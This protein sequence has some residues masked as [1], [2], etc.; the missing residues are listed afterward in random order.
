MH[1]LTK[2]RFVE[3]GVPWIK[4][5]FP[6]Q[7]ECFSAFHTS[8]TAD[9]AN[10]LHNISLRTLPKLHSALRAKDL[11]LVICRTMS[12]APWHWQWINRELFSR[13][14]LQGASRLSA[15][16]GPQMLRVPIS[17]PIAVLDTEDYPVIAQNNFFLLKRSRLYF[18]R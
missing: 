1:D 12:Y 5:A 18:K 7:T 13:R 11:A 6:Q 2:F 17:A 8:R 15:G 9:P 14:A 3:I 10:G 4:A 16:L